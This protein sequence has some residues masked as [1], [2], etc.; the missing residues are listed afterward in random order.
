MSEQPTRKY[1]GRPTG[2]TGVCALAREAGLSPGIITRK[3]QLGRTREEILED[4][5][6]YHDKKAEKEARKKGIPFVSSLPPLPPPVIPAAKFAAAVEAPTPPAVKRKRGRPPKVREGDPV[7]T[8]DSPIGGDADESFYQ[9]Q[10]REKIATATLKEL[11]LQ[12]KRGELVSVKRV[13]S[14]WTDI[15]TSIRD[16]VLGMPLKL[17][18]RLAAMTDQRQIELFLK[19][20]F[21]AELGKI[22]ASVFSTSGSTNSASA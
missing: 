3:L 8:A 7:Q 13:E 2:N 6:R 16:S 17:S 10:R 19:E 15:A 18:G 12:E 1:F 21:R 22:S 14:E 4:A 11:D 5:R 9:A 20:S